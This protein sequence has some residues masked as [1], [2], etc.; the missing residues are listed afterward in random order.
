MKI[1]NKNVLKI[2]LGMDI[3]YITNLC[4]TFLHQNLFKLILIS[5]A[6]LSNS[7]ADFLFVDIINSIKKTNKTFIGC[8]KVS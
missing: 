4:L 6:T 8:K 1:L 3:K 5:L 2:F 7:K